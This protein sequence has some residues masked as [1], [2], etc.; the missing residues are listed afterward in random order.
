MIR[1]ALQFIRSELEAYIVEREQDPA[2]YSSG[3][4]VDLRSIALA[5]GNINVINSTHVTIMVVGVDEERREGKRP[6]FVP[7]DNNQYLRLNPP[8][9][10]DVYVLFAAHNSNYENALRDISDVISFFQ[11]NV[12]FDSQRYP[13]LNATVTSPTTKPWQLI[14][15]LTF[16]LHCLTFEQQNNLWGMIGSKYLPNVVYKMN[17][18]TIFDTKGKDKVAAVTELNF[19]EN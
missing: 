15:R 2:N 9:E 17:M 6:Y 19:I 3:N 8:V 7:A 4:V 13:A 5:N 14:D 12:V 16:R 10:I 1:T 18:L 11:S